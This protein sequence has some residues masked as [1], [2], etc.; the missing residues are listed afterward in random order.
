M[1]RGTPA[2]IIALAMSVNLVVAMVIGSGSGSRDYHNKLPSLSNS[3]SLSAAAAEAA[4]PLCHD[5]V[6]VARG[7]V[8]AAFQVQGAGGVVA[9]ND[10]LCVTGGV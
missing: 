10:S 9:L 8:A 6:Q 5:E 4:S 7:N 2:E 3:S 1:S